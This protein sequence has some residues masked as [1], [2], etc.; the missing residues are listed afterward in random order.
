MP[1]S[2]PQNTDILIIGAGFSGL[3]A[4]HTLRTTH[5]SLSAHIL[6]AAPDL[7]GVWHWNRYPGARV[8]S[9]WP[10]YQ[11][12]IPSAWRDF[13]F[14]ERFPG[15]E[16]IRQYFKHLD[17]VLDFKRDV[18]FNQRVDGAIWDEGEGRWV[19]ST[20]GGVVVRARYLVL[21]SGLL[22][23]PYIIHSSSYPP[24]LTTSGK[25]IAVIG[26]GATGVQ[27]VQE[28]SKTASH[29]T[30]YMRRPSP[31]L[32]MRNRPLTQEEHESWRP[33][34]PALFD[35]SRHSRSG[36]PFAQAPAPTPPSCLLGGDQTQG[37]GERKEKERARQELDAYYEYLWS[38]GSFNFG[39]SNFPAVYVSEEANRLAYGFWARK[40]RARMRDPVKRDLMAPVEPVDYL[41][42][43]RTPLEQDFYESVDR[44]NVDVVRIREGFRFTERGGIVVDG[45][46]ERMFD[47]VVL[48]TG[49][50]SY[51]GAISN[52]NIRGRNGISLSETWQSG[53][54][55]YLGITVHGFPNCF[56]SYTPHGE[57]HHPSIHLQKILT[58]TKMKAPTP[59]S[60]GPTIIES[61]IRLI[62]SLISK[63]ISPGTPSSTPTDTSKLNSNLEPN[64]ESTTQSE[65]N[66]RLGTIEPTLPAQVSYREMILAQAKGTLFE[67]TDSWW[68]GANVPGKKREVVTYL[69]GI[70]EYERFCAERIEGLIGFEIGEKVKSIQP[71]RAA[72]TADVFTELI[73]SSILI[74][75]QPHH[76]LPT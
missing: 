53:I 45:D 43:R 71:S 57:S 31:C 59:L 33:F 46:D 40:T 19:V 56:M 1:P 6:E 42:M 13:T 68:N 64:H 69:G 44:E 52:M 22:H 16:E 30:L 18:T 29:L 11:L 8:D 32:P 26:A 66:Q 17:D 35:A 60:N 47:V 65:P 41:F 15:H 12:T 5:P 54:Q 14:S 20:E 36:I 58:K 49:F 34:F 24:N 48:A 67:R 2:T 39:A 23:K 61:Q 75:S 38:S 50:D 63:S 51:S 76:L 10:F 9:E 4:L 25:R 27:I 70:E 21:C 7:G 37:E 73:I 3:S 28:L 72:E 55:T 62:A 74:L